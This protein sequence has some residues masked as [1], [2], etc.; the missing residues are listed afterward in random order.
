[1]FNCSK[2][3]ALMD[4]IKFLRTTNQSLTDRLAELAGSV[5]R[6]SQGDPDGFG[7]YGDGNDQYVAYNDIGQKILVESK[8]EQSING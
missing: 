1:M 4:E 6:S 2:C 5:G 8:K 3:E 7:Y